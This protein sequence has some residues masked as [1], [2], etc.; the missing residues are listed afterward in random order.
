MVDCS[1][2]ASLIVLENCGSGVTNC[3]PVE[4]VGCSGE[5]DRV[6]GGGS[7]KET[8]DEEDLEEEGS[9]EELEHEEDLDQDL[10][11][12]SEEESNEDSDDD[13]VEAVAEGKMEIHLSSK[14]KK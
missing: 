3:K 13:D 9:G 2:W 5:V 10:E 11:E 1:R 8:K 4:L 6:L 12:K 7:L 14:R